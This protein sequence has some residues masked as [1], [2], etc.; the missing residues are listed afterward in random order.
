VEVGG[1]GRERGSGDWRWREVDEAAS[2]WCGEIMVTP[3]RM[4]T[5]LLG[6]QK[7]SLLRRFGWPPQIRSSNED[8]AGVLFLNRVWIFSYKGSKS[9]RAR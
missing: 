9:A 7:W 2:L 5:E 3:H 1:E 4:R 8:P 6:Q